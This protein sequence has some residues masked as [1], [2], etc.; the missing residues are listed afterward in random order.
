V[1]R[2]AT[3][4]QSRSQRSMSQASASAEFIPAPT[5]RTVPWARGGAEVY[6]HGIPPPRHAWPDG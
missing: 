2:P 6:G 3:S 1:Y 5:A 4:T